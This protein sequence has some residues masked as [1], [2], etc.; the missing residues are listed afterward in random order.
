M[1]AASYLRLE[2]VRKRFADVVAVDDVS[3]DIVQGEFFALLGGSGSG[4]STLLRM[5]AGLEKPD[6]GRILIDSVN[7]IFDSAINGPTIVSPDAEQ[8]IR[9]GADAP[10][11]D[12]DTA[13]ALVAGQL[14][15]PHTGCRNPLDSPYEKKGTVCTKSITGTCF[16]CPNALMFFIGQQREALGR[17]ALYEFDFGIE[18]DGSYQLSFALPPPV[19]AVAEHQEAKP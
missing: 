9:A 6:A 16:A 13:S 18:R 17:L 12:Q 7:D 14:D 3:L 11:L 4:K 8:A 2:G 19:K 15:G 10:G 5:L 1:T